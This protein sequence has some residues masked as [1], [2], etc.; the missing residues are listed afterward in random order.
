MF[1]LAI[2]ELAAALL[3]GDSDDAAIEDIS[4]EYGLSSTGLRNSAV[5][6]LGELETYA[7]RHKATVL[8][9]GS[10]ASQ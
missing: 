1:T 9:D 8:T 5:E 6:A 7:E 10:H 4:C 2:T 3:S